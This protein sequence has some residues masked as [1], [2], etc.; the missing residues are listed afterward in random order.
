LFSSELLIDDLCTQGFHI[1]DNFFEVQ[2]YQQLRALAFNLLEEN[3]FQSAK[4]GSNI[5]A[6]HNTSVRKDK[7]H[8]FDNSNREPSILAYLK[9]MS[10]IVTLL[11]QS[12]FLGLQEI[13]SHFSVY[14]PGSFYKKHID[15]FQTTKTRKISCVYY[16]NEEWSASYG[17]TLKLYSPLDKLIQE[18]NPLGNRFIC[19]NSELPHEVTTTQQTRY[20][21]TGWMKTRASDTVCI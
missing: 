8:W 2:H 5:Q 12:L 18:I 13:E 7:I 4:I 3:A 10:E 17:G 21:I 11:N 20:S 1:I 16:L 6:Q 14:Q 15:Q 19:F 9:R